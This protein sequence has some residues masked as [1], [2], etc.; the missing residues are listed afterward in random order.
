MVNTK[1]AYFLFLLCTS[2]A[3]YLGLFL[4]LRIPNVIF[5]HPVENKMPTLGE[6]LSYLNTIHN[7][8]HKHKQIRDKL[9]ISIHDGIHST[10]L[11]K[12]MLVLVKFTAIFLYKTFRSWHGNEPFFAVGR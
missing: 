12:K 11:K 7:F 9:V 10:A 6:K 3:H 8:F 2:V 4:Q 1:T 5:H